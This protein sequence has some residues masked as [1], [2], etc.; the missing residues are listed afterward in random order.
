[1][2]VSRIRQ[3]PCVYVII[4]SYIKLFYVYNAE[5]A[6]DTTEDD[7]QDTPLIL[8]IKNYTSSVDRHDWTADEDI[9]LKVIDMLIKF[10]M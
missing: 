7:I 9:N 6:F 10:G 8:A 4:Y 2:L 5:I 1:M 3:I